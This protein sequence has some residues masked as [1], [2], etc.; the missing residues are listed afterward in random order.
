MPPERP[1]PALPYG[2]EPQLIINLAAD[3]DAGAGHEHDS[4]LLDRGIVLSSP[5]EVTIGARYQPPIGEQPP[6]VELRLPLPRS[7][8]PQTYE[9]GSSGAEVWMR[10]TRH[11]D[12]IDSEIDAVTG[13][14]SLE[15]FEPTRG[16][17]VEGNAELS[18]EGTTVRVRFL[19]FL[20][21]V[22]I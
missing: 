17:I 9:V 3:S 1:R 5:D 19:T 6:L 4:P 2:F 8:V 22:A 18:V 12:P 7:G 13:E 11:Q 15:R 21:D 14:V 20:R 16:A 10:F